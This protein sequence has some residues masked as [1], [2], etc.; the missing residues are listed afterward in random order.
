MIILHLMTAATALAIPNDGGDR[1]PLRCDRAKITACIELNASQSRQELAR[2]EELLHRLGLAEADN[3]ALQA[4]DSGLKEEERALLV[5]MKFSEAEMKFSGEPSTTAPIFP[6][7]PTPEQLPLL[8]KESQSWNGRLTSARLE[9][10]TDLARQS[11][12]EQEKVSALRRNLA[13][14]IHALTGEIA[15]IHAAIQAAQKAA[16][17]HAKMCDG[18]CDA[19]VCPQI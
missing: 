18:G 13:M 4:R 1:F 10:L 8:V 5:T 11:R 2:A 7:G 9:R 14:Q 19:A 15:E 16:A 17:Q 12:L 3:A 6:S